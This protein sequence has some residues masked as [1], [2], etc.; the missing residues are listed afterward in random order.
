[1]TQGGK[2]SKNLPS[3]DIAHDWNPFW[4]LRQEDPKS[5]RKA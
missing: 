2:K 3:G 1:M 4:R 5:L